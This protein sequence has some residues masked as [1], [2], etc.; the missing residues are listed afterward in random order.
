MAQTTDA[1]PV[2]GAAGPSLGLYPKLHHGFFSTCLVE[3]SGDVKAVG[4]N[5]PLPSM[6]DFS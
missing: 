1:T 3:A 2:M 4:L 5:L 6:V